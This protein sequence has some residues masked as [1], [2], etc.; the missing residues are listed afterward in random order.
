LRQGLESSENP[1]HT[2]DAYYSSWGS[3][4]KGK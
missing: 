1:W 2:T 4:M 3:P